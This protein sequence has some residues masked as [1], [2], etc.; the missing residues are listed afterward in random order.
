LNNGS[1]MNGRILQTNKMP[2]K[3]HEQVEFKSLS[4]GEVLSLRGKY[5]RKRFEFGPAHRILNLLRNILWEPMFIMLVI[6][7][8]LYF[9]LGETGEGIMMSIAVILVTA[10]SVYQEVKSHRAIRSLHQLTD[11]GVTVIRDG[12]DQRINS[13][14]LVPGDIMRLNEGVKIPADALLLQAN[15]LSVDESL[16]TG[17][18]LP[19][20][21]SVSERENLIYQGTTVNS[22]KCIARVTFTGN[23][24]RLGG[25]G[26]DITG[27]NPPKTQ[28]QKQI[29]KFVRKLALFG[30][31]AFVLIFIL[32]YSNAGFTG[33]LLFA[34]T[35]AMSAI[36]EEIPVA[37]SSFMALG[38]YSMSKL[39]IIARQA[40]SIE[41]LG[42]I[43]V[44]CL[45]KTG[46]LTENRM[47]VKA[48]YCHNSK[49][50]I[51]PG[52]PVTKEYKNIV[53]YGT[54]ASEVEP[55]DSMEQAILEANMQEGNP[56]DERKII[57]EYPLEGR[58]PMMTHVYKMHDQFIVAGKGAAERL[59]RVCHL[60]R[61]EK[62]KINEQVTLFTRKGFRVIGVAS[63]T[64]NGDLPGR[65]DD[66]KWQFL[67]L[68]ALYDPPKQNVRGV[69]QKISEAGIAL[70]LITGDHPETA[71][72]I[73]E[74][75]GFPDFTLLKT[76][77]DILP[78]SD[79]EL[80]SVV[81]TTNIFARMFPEA[82]LKVIRAIQSNGHIVAMTGDGIN[83]GPALKAA[84]VGI[85][86]GKKGTDT[87][88]Q[89]ADI[90]LTDDNLE[91]IWVSVREGRRIFAN[92]VKAIRYIIS[93][94]I[95]IILTAS[96][97]LIL[98]WQYLNIFTPIHVIFL[99]LIMGPTCS[100]FFEREP[101][102]DLSMISRP[103]NRT[104]GLFTREEL[105]LSIVQG[106]LITA[107]ILVLYWIY[108]K[109]GHTIEAV[110][111][112][113]FITILLS[114]IFLTFVNRSL[115]RTIFHTI[116]YRNNLTI[117]IL[118]AT[119]LYLGLLLF[120][121]PAQNLFGLVPLNITQFWLCTAVAFGTV[122]WVEMYK[123]IRGTGQPVNTII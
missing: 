41:N 73:A 50:V 121:P 4:A 87:A 100:I 99:E 81:S 47:K 96:L 51:E 108:M 80:K 57:F 3:L 93:I 16:I 90:I 89:A 52:N 84:D 48:I 26:K 30:L 68:I 94:H 95:P 103:R 88:K 85:A 33:S 58:P 98:G 83:D 59:I 60:I 104:R 10:I 61:D 109:N 25:I 6:A 66:F 101:V 40:Q 22:G 18:S 97:P 27:Y 20:Y 15:D 8:S 46:T 116:R 69:L 5:G 53:W 112:L 111:T 110:R 49:Q 11:P 91:K 123:I 39:G 35:L 45:D 114:N 36:P 106:L 31:F 63:A 34:L 74:L 78:M 23:R 14:E 28:L 82:K 43:T 119:V 115:T 102:E 55:F 65:Q 54:L 118:L 7:S 19:V 79:E 62:E 17:E 92:L 1:V 9:I 122:M 72:T 75:T 13:E 12:C 105:V 70:K 38:A 107:G 64:H 77:E 56:A 29:G 76:G 71:T 24:T 32:N 44:L 67:G 42:A 21:K 37:F 113:V 117:F 86:M 120:Y 2:E